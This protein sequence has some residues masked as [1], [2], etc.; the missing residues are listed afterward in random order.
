MVTLPIIQC[1]LQLAQVL[2]PVDPGEIL[3]NI[4]MDKVLILMD[5]RINNWAMSYSLRFSF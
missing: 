5:P 1:E 4:L 3:H 2:A